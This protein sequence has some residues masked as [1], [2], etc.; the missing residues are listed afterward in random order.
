[1]RRSIT[2]ISAA[3]TTFSLVV[4]GSVVYAYRV[5]AAARPNQ[6]AAVAT[7]PLP[8]HAALPPVA[9]SV[10]MSPQDAA[11][12]AAKFLSRTDPYSVQ[13]SDFNGTQAYK[14]TFSSGDVVFIGLDGLVLGTVPAP[15]QV[16]SAG[17]S[18]G[19]GNHGGGHQKGEVSGGGGSGSDDGGHSEPGEAGEGGD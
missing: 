13:L 5:L 16:A 9:K 19:G 17:P 4:L 1:M 10:N 6:V 18:S 14:V 2:M 11:A 7:Q 15:A 8:E 12:A 3:I